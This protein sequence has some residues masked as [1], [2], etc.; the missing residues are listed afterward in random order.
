M[1]ISAKTIAQLLEGSVEGNP[2]ALVNSPGKIEEGGEGVITFLANPKYEEF[3]YT[4]TATILLVSNEFKPRKPIAATLVR[5]PDVYKAVS[6]LLEKFAPDAN[7]GAT[8]ISPQAF[9]H[10][11]ATTGTSC[12]VGSFVHIEEGAVLGD[13]VTVY[14]QVYIGKDARIG[15][16]TILYP[17]V[18]ILRGCTV[19]ERCVLHANVVVGS[20]GFGFAPQEDGRYRK[21]AQIGTVII[22]DDVE[23]GANTTIDRATM[24]ATRIRKGVKLDNLIQIAHNV[25]IGENTVIASQTGIAGS[26]KIGKNC[27]IGGQVGIVGHIEIADHTKIQAQSGINKSLAAEG[28]AWYGSPALPYSDFLRAYSLF[29]RLPDLEKRL[30]AIEKENR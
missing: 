30:G 13:R 15:S 28:A 2:E 8:G 1:Y 3:A 27:Q 5:V 14:P 9:I 17:G 10:A 19:G 22:E 7:E 29:K 11:N 18:R 6:L 24:G 26:A 23:I 4:T 20:D 12:S 25:E 16:D 21:I